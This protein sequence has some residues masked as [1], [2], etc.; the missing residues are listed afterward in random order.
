MLRENFEDLGDVMQ[1]EDPLVE[2]ANNAQELTLEAVEAEV[3]RIMPAISAMGGVIE[4]LNVDPI[5]VVEM[6]F[7]GPNR[8]Q[9]G[10]ELAIL[11]V[12]FVK[13]VKFVN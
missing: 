10:L 6:S 5:G 11:D 1:V 13:H 4:I 9:H 12:P 3:R 8:V 2:A 7:R